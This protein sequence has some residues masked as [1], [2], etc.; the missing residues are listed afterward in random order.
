MIVYLIRNKINGKI[1]IG[2]EVTT[3]SRYYGSGVLIK[4]AIKKYGKSNFTKEILIE[5]STLEELTE[6]EKYYIELYRSRD[7][8]VGY[9]IALGGTGGDTGKSWFKQYKVK[10]FLIKKHGEKEGIVRY[11]QIKTKQMATRKDR[12]SLKE[13][14]LRKN[15][16]P[17]V[18]E[19]WQQG[20]KV[21]DIYNKLYPNISI[22]Y[23][24]KFLKELFEETRTNGHKKSKNRGSSNVNS[25]LSD[26]DV[27]EIRAK[28]STL[29]NKADIVKYKKTIR[30]FYKLS[31]STV[32]DLIRGKSYKHLL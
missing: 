5:C 11:N 30:E 8:K 24:R 26:K 21:N 12:E 4:A 9:N 19:L 27:F 7:P 6:K 28:V 15:F 16:K 1:Y 20:V 13:E 2:K 18:I 10:D 17:Q 3:K 25:K 31:A 29:K 14:Y 22:L 32:N 23:I